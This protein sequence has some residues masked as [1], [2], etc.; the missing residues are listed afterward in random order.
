MPK[1]DCLYEQRTTDD[2][3]MQGIRLKIANLVLPRMLHLQVTCKV[4]NQ[5]Q[6]VYCAYLG[7]TR[8]FQFRGCARSKPQFL[9]AVQSLQLFRWTQ[10]YVCMDYQLLN[11]RN[12]SWKHFPVSQALETLSVTHAKESCRLIH[13]LTLV[14]LSQLT[15]FHRTFPRVHTQ[16]KSSYSKTMLQ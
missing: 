7:H 9:T 11:F 5:R 4:Q 15:T 13:I 3:V 16:P 10:V 2:S 14:F 8:L 12:V 1:E 6:E